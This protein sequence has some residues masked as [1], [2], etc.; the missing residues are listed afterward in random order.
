MSCYWFP[1]ILKAPEMFLD[2]PDFLVIG[3]LT[4]G[5]LLIFQCETYWIFSGSYSCACGI[6]LLSEERLKKLSEQQRSLPENRYVLLCGCTVCWVLQLCFLHSAV[7]LST[8]ILNIW[9]SL[10]PVPERFNMEAKKQNKLQHSSSARLYK[11]SEHSSQSYF[12][13][14]CITTRSLASVTR[15]FNYKN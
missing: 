7:M 9:I 4:C 5:I 14:V 13:S 12:F 10:F 15:H 1:F 8:T 3:V 6:G 2:K 11:G